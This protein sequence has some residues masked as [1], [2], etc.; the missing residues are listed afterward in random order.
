MEN[1]FRVPPSDE[2]ACLLDSNYLKEKWG[3]Y[4]TWWISVFLPLQR[5]GG[6]SV[7]GRKFRGGERRS[8]R[9]SAVQGVFHFPPNSPS[10]PKKPLQVH[11]LPSLGGAVKWEEKRVVPRQLTLCVLQLLN[12][13]KETWEAVSQQAGN[14]TQL[15]LLF[16]RLSC[17]SVYLLSAGYVPGIA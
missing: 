11:P 8:C 16:V 5:L 10:L 3:C 14:S 9:V 13:R 12:R 1:A 6:K 7:E 15:D 17:F 4:F 2:Q